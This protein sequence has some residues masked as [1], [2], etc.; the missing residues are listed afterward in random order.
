[1]TE[2]E[3]LIYNL[4]LKVSR[5]VQNKPYRFRNNF[6]KLGEDKQMY[7]KKLAQFF[8][9]HKH[10]NIE[11]FFKS[12]YHIYEDKPNLDLKFYTSLKACKLYFD[13]I[14]SKNKHD[15]NSKETKSFYKNSALFVTKY[16]IENK[17]TWDEYIIYKVNEFDRV[18]AFFSHLKNGD[19]SIYF[20]MSFN[21][22]EPEFKKHDR[23]VIMHML[24]DTINSISQHRLKFYNKKEETKLFFDKVFNLCKNKVDSSLD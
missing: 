10:I 1:M 18:N 7:C 24:N 14:K 8:T 17:I 6:E 4:H 5:T 16:C 13:F 11:T 21:N 2:F 12:P 19:V 23:E 22:F 9:K 3:Q 15:I 20:L